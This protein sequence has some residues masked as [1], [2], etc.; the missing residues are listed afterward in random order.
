MDIRTIRMALIKYAIHDGNYP[1][2]KQGLQAL[3]VEPTLP[4]KPATWDGPHIDPDFLVDPWGSKYVYRSPSTEDPK[5]HRYDL[6]SY[7]PNSEEG[8]DDDISI[9]DIEKLMKQR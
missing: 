6:Y 7:G 2:T 5:L 4:P 1:T 9:R 8:D 3:I